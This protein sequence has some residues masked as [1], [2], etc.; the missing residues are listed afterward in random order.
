M[1]RQAGQLRERLWVLAAGSGGG[2]WP[3]VLA[4]W[5]AARVISP[6]GAYISPEARFDHH[7]RLTPPSIV[8]VLPVM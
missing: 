1:P 2:V 3:R 5:L 8:S 7:G 6:G 4:T